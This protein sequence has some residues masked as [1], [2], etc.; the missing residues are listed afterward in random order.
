MQKQ[1]DEGDKEDMAWTG[2]CFSWLTLLAG[3]LVWFGVS[4]LLVGLLECRVKEESRDKELAG[5]GSRLVLLMAPG[6][7]LGCLPRR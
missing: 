5:L 3:L 4:D 7:P 1:L 6:R 2:G